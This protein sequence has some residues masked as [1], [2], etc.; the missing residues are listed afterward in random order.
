[1]VAAKNIQLY[2]RN[3]ALCTGK[4]PEKVVYYNKYEKIKN[5]RELYG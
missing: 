2:L 4:I 3:F 5:G 1:M